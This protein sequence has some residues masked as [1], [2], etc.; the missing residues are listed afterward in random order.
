MNLADL[1]HAL[2]VEALGTLLLS[3][4]RHRGHVDLVVADLHAQ[5]FA[6]HGVPRNDVQHVLDRLQLQCPEWL[7]CNPCDAT[8]TWANCPSCGQTLQSQ[9][10]LCHVLTLADGCKPLEVVQESCSACKKTFCGCW[11]W[12]HGSSGQAHL[13]RP[14]RADVILL[15]CLCPERTSVAGMDPALFTFLTASQATIYLTSSY[16]SAT[17]CTQQTFTQRSFHT[18]ARS[19]CTQKLL[20]KETLT[21]KR[22]Y[23]KAFTQSSFYTGNLR[24]T[25]AFTQGS[26]CTEKLL[27]TE[28]FAHRSFYT[29][30]HSCC[31][32]T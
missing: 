10:S 19:F 13:A 24:H 15:L 14:V 32:T 5:G 4:H 23:Y 18:E 22:L 17:F 31:Q 1:L 21:R 30:L 9:R 2:A 26:F 3:Y 7:V 27:H 12:I 29:E 8:S 20:H 16:T 6:P 25:E 28:G 11:S